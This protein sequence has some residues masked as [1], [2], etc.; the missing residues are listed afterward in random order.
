MKVRATIILTGLAAAVVWGLPGCKTPE[1]ERPHLVGSPGPSQSP[2]PARRPEPPQASDDG[3]ES[4]RQ[5]RHRSGALW[6]RIELSADV[7]HI[8]VRLVEPPTTASFFLPTSPPPQR[9]TTPGLQVDEALGPDGPV[10]TERVISAHRIDIDARGLQWVEFRYRLDLNSASRAKHPLAPVLEGSTRLLYMPSVLAVPSARIA[11]GLTDIP[12]E[13]HLPSSWSATTT[14]D[15]VGSE[16][17]AHDSRRQVHGFLARDFREL[18]D[19]YLAAGPELTTVTRHS[20]RHRIEITFGPGFDRGREAIADAIGPLLG[21]YRRQ[22]GHL[23]P[24][25]AFV[26]ARRPDGSNDIHGQGRRGGFVVS[27]PPGP[28]GKQ[29]LLLLAHEAFHLWNGHRIVPSPAAEPE[30]RW[31]KEGVT[32]Y[33]ALKTLYTLG[34]FERRDVLDEIARAAYLYDHNPAARSRPGIDPVDRRR[35]PYDRGLLIGLAMDAALTESSRGE[36]GIEHW[37]RRLLRQENGGPDRL[38]D[39][40][41]LKSAFFEVTPQRCQRCRTLWSRYVQ[42][43]SPLDLD[44]IFAHGGLHLLDGGSVDQMRLLPLQGASLPFRAYFPFARSE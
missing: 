24:V 35:L 13:L 8:R 32:H 43:E 9:Q 11:R 40:K 14:W 15:S 21:F 37:F 22:F 12:V 38:V 19:A 29:S 25:S 33:I 28:P 39:T 30:T 34:V 1:P 20:R 31:F 5:S 27:M 6:Y 36:V 7:A 10:D 44:D 23:G 26:Q 42:R 16:P 18:R 41:S 17:S 2:P 4:T 3:N